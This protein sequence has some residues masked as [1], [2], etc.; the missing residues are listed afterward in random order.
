[1]LKKTESE[2]TKGF[3]SYFYDWWHTLVLKSHGFKTGF[4]DVIIQQ[5]NCLGH[6]HTFHKFSLLCP[7][8]QTQ[9]Q[10][11]VNYWGGCSCRP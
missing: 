10:T 3:L 2:E 9:M 4:G 7:R 6:F 5:Q 1:M 11:E 8:E